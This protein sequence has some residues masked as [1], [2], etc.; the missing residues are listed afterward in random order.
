MSLPDLKCSFR[1]VAACRLKVRD[2][3]NPPVFLAG[4]FEQF[5]S[6]AQCLH[7]IRR[8]GT[9]RHGVN[10]RFQFG[11]V[12]GEFGLRFVALAETDQREA[13]VAIRL[14]DDGFGSLFGLLEAIAETHTEGRIQQD[15]IRPPPLTLVSGVAA[16]VR[17][18]ERQRQQQKRQAAQK[19]QQPVLHH[20]LANGF[21]RHAPDEHQRRE[22]DAR[23]FGAPHQMHDDWRGDRRQTK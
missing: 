16:E 2:Q 18:H 15:D 21:L 7:I 12:A 19:Q 5:R 1:R 3:N 23:R 17:P 13:F 20:P 9:D 8:T 10:R 6:A 4:F 14:F 22:F 11:G